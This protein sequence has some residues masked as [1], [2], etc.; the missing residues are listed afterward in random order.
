MFDEHGKVKKNKNGPMYTRE[1]SELTCYHIAHKE[2]WKRHLISA[3]AEKI[4][5][6]EE[7]TEEAKKA[8]KRKM[9]KSRNSD[10]N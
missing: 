7:A 8:K 3:Q 4:T 9:N 5:Q 1:Y 2:A 10:K 6:A